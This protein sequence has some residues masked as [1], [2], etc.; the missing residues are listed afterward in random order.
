MTAPDDLSMCA[1][2]EAAVERG[3]V[4]AL[5]DREL[6]DGVATLERL[7]AELWTEIHRRGEDDEGE[8]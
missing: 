3:L 5:T 6:A 8:L 4:S 2:L 7:R 1:R